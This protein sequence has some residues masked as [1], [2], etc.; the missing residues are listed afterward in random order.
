MRHV[1]PTFPRDNFNTSDLLKKHVLFLEDA[2]L[3]YKRHSDYLYWKTDTH[4]NQM[5]AYLGYITLMDSLE[6]LTQ[7]KLKRVPLLGWHTDGPYRGD[8]ARINRVARAGDNM[9]DLL[10]PLNEP[11]SISMDKNKGGDTSTY[12]N[13]APLNPLN[14]VLVV[15][16]FYNILPSVYRRTF[17]TTHE[18]HY[19]KFDK[20]SIA[21]L[22][23]EGPTIDLLIFL[24]VERS[25]PA[26][27]RE[28]HQLAKPFIMASDS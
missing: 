2:L 9:V 6:K 28:L 7:K 26:R 4:W 15:D 24:L 17:H 1:T 12:F 18:I 25:I 14:A 19:S 23:E 13:V 3:E 20:A 16:S 5:G 10:F 22:L 27:D 8:L 21:D 11:E